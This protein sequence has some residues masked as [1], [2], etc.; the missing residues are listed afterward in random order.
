LSSAE[1]KE[2]KIEL[3]SIKKELKQQKASANNGITGNVLA[4]IIG[5]VLGAVLILLFLAGAFN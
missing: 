1:K 3:F 4:L 2:L 5:G